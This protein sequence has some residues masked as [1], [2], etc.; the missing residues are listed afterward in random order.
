MAE[1]LLIFHRTCKSIP[2]TQK[3]VVYAKTPQNILYPWPAVYCPIL[4]LLWITDNHNNKLHHNACAIIVTRHQL[5][6]IYQSF[7]ST[8][9]NVNTLLY[10]VH[11]GR[12]VA[13]C[14]CTNLDYKHSYQVANVLIDQYAIKCLWWHTPVT[15]DMYRWLHFPNTCVYLGQLLSKHT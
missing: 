6:Y 11:T 15:T 5:R 9:P 10:H 1:T 8:I 13:S 7:S 3:Y 2:A 12:I 4:C 14:C